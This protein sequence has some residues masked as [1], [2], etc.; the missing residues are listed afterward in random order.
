MKKNYFYPMKMQPVYKD[1]IWGGQKLNLLN[2]HCDSINIAESWEVSCNNAGLTKIANGFFAGK[3]LN[4]V[5]QTNWVDFVGHIDNN[6]NRFPLIVKFIDAQ[7]DLSIQVHPDE[8]SMDINNNEFCKSELWYIIDCEPESYI[9]YGFSRDISKKEFLDSVK[10]KKICSLLNKIKVNK[11]DFYFIPAGTI[12]ALGKGILVS[13]IQQNSTTT[14]R[15]FDYERKDFDGNFRD[16]HIERA[17]NVVNLKKTL[18]WTQLKN[19]FFSVKKEKII[20]KKPF[21]DFENTFSIIQ[22][23]SGSGK[24]IYDD[25]QFDCN[26]GDTFFI[27]AKITSYTI[28]GNCEILFIKP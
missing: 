20:D 27:P 11:G 2:K 24:I 3:T 9:Y 22:F 4:D 8:K 26:L 18:P 28:A 15:I 17:K 5:I 21:D 23:I 25:M 16:L 12:H 1:Y 14:F 7:K 13:E 10:E 6:L 19:K